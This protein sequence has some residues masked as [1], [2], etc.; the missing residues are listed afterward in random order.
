[1]F[2]ASSITGFSIEA[3][4]G[5]IGSVSDFLFEDRNWA[6]RWVVVDT[7]NW[8]S[9]RKVLL[10]PRQVAQ[11]EAKKRRFRVN[12]TKQQVKDSPDVDTEQPVSRQMETDIYGYYGADP[13]WGSVYNPTGVMAMPG[14]VGVP[15]LAAPVLAEG[16][17]E[18]FARGEGD[19]H[20]RSTRAVTGYHI[21]ARDGEIG[22]VD[23]FVID[24]EGW[25]IPYLIVDT[26]NW[27]PGKKV[28]IPTSSARDIVWDDR[29]VYL[30]L[31]RGEIKNGPLYDPARPLS[32]I[33]GE[34]ELP[35]RSRSR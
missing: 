26:K 8:L 30:A 31:S 3:T 16:L 2:T 5:T 13:Y 21:H 1:M 14:V 19:P 4:D 9:G 28:L 15:P 18:E 33:A 22:H 17:V 23:D 11:A 25:A 10:T 27:W 7:G 35:R 6:I 32:R 29:L 24:D 12:L 20:L 34:S